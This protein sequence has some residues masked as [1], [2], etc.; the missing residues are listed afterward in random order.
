MQHIVFMLQN[1]SPG[2]SGFNDTSPRTEE[3][4]NH[5]AHSLCVGKPTRHEPWWPS[6]DLKETPSHFPALLFETN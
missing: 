1:L 3:K 4:E 5:Q 2:A 6:K